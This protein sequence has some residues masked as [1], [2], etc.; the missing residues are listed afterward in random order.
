[1]VQHTRTSRLVPGTINQGDDTQNVARQCTPH[2]E[3]AHLYSSSKHKSSLFGT[4][5]LF[6]L[7]M[8]L[9]SLVPGSRG[10]RKKLSPQ[11]LNDDRQF[12][13]IL[14]AMAADLS[15]STECLKTGEMK[16]WFAELL[17]HFG[18]DGATLFELLED[19][20]HSLPLYSPNDV[21]G[22]TWP[23]PAEK[24][25]RQALARRQRGNI[26][27]LASDPSEIL[28]R[29]PGLKDWLHCRSSHFF[30][31][32]P[33]RGARELLGIL[34]FA[35]IKPKREYPPAWREDLQAVA[36]IVANI[37]RQRTEA[38][39]QANE[40]LKNSIL[41][42]FPSNVAVIDRDGTIVAV[43]SN[44]LAFAANNGVL[45][46]T[47]IG[48]GANYLSECKKAVEKGDVYAY[49]A[50]AGINS[51]L[52]GESDSFE[53]DYPCS[54]TTEQ[55][56]YTLLATRLM[57]K[58]GGAVV[59]HMDVTDRILAA[60]RLRESENRF[61]L[62]AN[63]APV[64]MW[65]SGADRLCTYFNQGW[66]DFTG[67]KLKQELGNGWAEGVHPEDY[68]N[69]L[70]TYNLAFDA[71]KKFTMEYRLRHADGKYHW[72]I[73][74][75]VPRFMNDG[76]F[77]GY[78]GCCFDIQDRKE[79]A[80]T[81]TEFSGRLI[82]A[83]EE[84][85]ARIA[86]ELHDDIGQRLALLAVDVEQ[87]DRDLTGLSP[88]HHAKLHELWTQI[89]EICTDAG[90][91]SHQL[92]SSKL[93]LLGLALAVRSL[94]DD[95]SKQHDVVIEYS[96]S[97]VP[98]ELDETISLCLFRVTQEALHNV[99]RHSKATK[100]KLTLRGTSRDLRLTIS[101]NGEGFNIDAALAGEGLGLIS[102]QER[103][104][105]VGG[106]LN[107]R[108]SASGTRIDAAVPLSASQ[109]T[110]ESTPK[111]KSRSAATTGD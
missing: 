36:S 26:T 48:P 31:V 4:F 78:I 54:S 40:E 107:L 70:Q 79:L 44:W 15:S 16:G 85:R 53:M 101:D 83:Q 38:L 47:S 45:S 90:R 109:L 55:R 51:V 89:N 13:D 60:A 103:L 3:P 71:Q 99:A 81:R 30:V 98:P 106:V 110:S 73:D 43:N 22:R 67:R 9:L 49:Q 39:L 100:V 63:A 17:H 6:A 61:E 64:L 74:S 57:R 2:L 41:S 69:C 42:S 34:V 65:M 19:G 84:E 25:E 35:G 10:N 80:V 52:Q 86:R 28:G 20:V 33:L 82:R 18:F 32:L 50:L 5:G 12:R 1:M 59:K 91:I 75:G 111:Q 68:Q 27:V 92:H 77:A 62:M 87:L 97:G 7:P 23:S 96:C 58:E 11:A 21:S 108:S 105:L 24:D 14:N 66:L 93:Q 56:W 88:D 104:R 46:D 76:T 95:F 8:F 37:L 72:I 94:C 29:F 102:M